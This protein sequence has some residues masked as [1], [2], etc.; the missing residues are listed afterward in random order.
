[1][2]NKPSLVIGNTS[3]LSYYF[4]D[5]FEK[6]SSRNINFV[7]LCEKSYDK[8]FILFAEQRTFLNESEEFFINTN[9]NYTIDVINRFKDISNKVII[10]STSELWNKYD[11]CVSISDTYNYNYSPYIKSKEILCNF[12]NDNRDIY[13]NVIIIYPF[14][15]NSVHRKEGFLFGKI[16]DSIISNKKISIGDINFNRDLT[17]PKNIVDISL[18]ADKDCIVGSGELFN[19]QRFIEDIFTKL[20][21]NII[22]YI[23]YDNSNNLNIKRG[24]YYNCEK[25]LNYDEL[26]NLTINDIYEYKT[27]KGHD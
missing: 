11:R 15:F 1:M 25:T 6:V 4:P 19:V 2:T 3:Q 16:F 12:I 18:K 21:K 13:S 24:G 27:S 5:N 20:N 23:E 9:F 10:Y 17:H 8:V 26:I 7:Q 22:D 14:N